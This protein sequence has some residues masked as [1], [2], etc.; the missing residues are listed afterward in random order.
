L[1]GLQSISLHS[2]SWPAGV[3]ATQS[4]GQFL[5]N[6]IITPLNSLAAIK[7]TPILSS[8]NYFPHYK[9]LKR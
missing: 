8:A 4:F 2:C 5:A 7:T 9:L 1:L 6:I 3:T